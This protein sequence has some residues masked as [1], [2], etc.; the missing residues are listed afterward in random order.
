[1][2]QSGIEEPFI[3]EDVSV[4]V[5]VQLRRKNSIKLSQTIERHNTIIEALKRKTKHELEELLLQYENFGN[6]WMDTLYVDNPF[7]YAIDSIVDDSLWLTYLQLMNAH[8][9]R[10]INERE[11]EDMLLRIM[12]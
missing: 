1:M 4:I 11:A 3:V 10:L 9:E 12:L 7:R 6:V 5:K 8:I 2:V